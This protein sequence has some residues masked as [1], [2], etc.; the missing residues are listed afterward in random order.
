M[1]TETAQI[2]ERLAKAGAKGAI[3]DFSEDSEEPSEGEEFYENEEE[4]K[5]DNEATEMH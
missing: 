4:G 2:K 3:M 1:R 5:E